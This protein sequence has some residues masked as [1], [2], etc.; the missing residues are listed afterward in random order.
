M[1]IY[2]L[3]LFSEMFRNQ[4]S[5]L[6]SK[7]VSQHN[8]INV[9]S[10][11]FPVLPAAALVPFYMFLQRTY[12]IKCSYQGLRG[13]IHKGKKSFQTCIMYMYVKIYKTICQ[14]FR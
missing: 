1:A 14:I 12:F 5:Y 10:V 3:L 7:F 8:Y 6:A 11:C 4:C 9:F 2:S 13:Y